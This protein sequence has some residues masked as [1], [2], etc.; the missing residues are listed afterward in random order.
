MLL[1]L[2][3][4]VVDVGGISRVFVVEP[5]FLNARVLL[6]LSSLELVLFSPVELDHDALSDEELKSSPPSFNKLVD[7]LSSYLWL[8]EVRA[9]TVLP[10]SN[11]STNDSHLLPGCVGWEDKIIRAWRTCFISHVHPLGELS[12]GLLT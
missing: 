1:R 9:K 10:A 6:L 2:L 11:L 5:D 4:G 3:W 8:D 7:D 12:K